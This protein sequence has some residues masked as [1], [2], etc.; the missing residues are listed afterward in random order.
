MTHKYWNHSNLIMLKQLKAVAERLIAAQSSHVSVTDLLWIARGVN[1]DTRPVRHKTCDGRSDCFY[2]WIRQNLYPA[3]QFYDHEAGRKGHAAH[4]WYAFMAPH[5]PQQM[6]NLLASFKSLE[7]QL[8][9]SNVKAA[10]AS[11]DVKSYMKLLPTDAYRSVLR[12]LLADIVNSKTFLKTEFG[13]ARRASITRR[14]K[15][16]RRCS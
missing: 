10:V 4:R 9:E 6:A 16:I 12:S 5:T 15:F 11:V 13:M 14:I 8:N 1:H 2:P 7:Q 3:V